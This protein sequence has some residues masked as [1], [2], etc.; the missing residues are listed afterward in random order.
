[1]Q[2]S[3]ASTGRK[4]HRGSRG[5]GQRS[6]LA[7]T[8]EPLATLQARQNWPYGMMMLSR[9]PAVLAGKKA[10]DAT[11]AGR[12]N[13]AAS[14]KPAGPEAMLNANQQAVNSTSPQP[15]KNPGNGR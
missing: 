10:Q 1:M 2:A 9:S 4:A 3:P 11:P 14:R 5:G 7:A 8:R 15:Q 6:A 12:P 13:P